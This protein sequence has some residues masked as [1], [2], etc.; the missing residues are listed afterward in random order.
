MSCLAK[1]LVPNCIIDRVIQ[2]QLKEADLKPETK[3]RL[4]EIKCSITV[5]GGLTLPAQFLENSEKGPSHES[6]ISKNIDLG[7]IKMGEGF[8]D[9]EP[10][11][12]KQIHHN[13]SQKFSAVILGEDDNFEKYSCA[14]KFTGIAT[15]NRCL[16]SL[17]DSDVM[18]SDKEAAPLLEDLKIVQDIGLPKSYNTDFNMQTDESFS[19]IFFYGMG[20][21]LLTKQEKVSESDLGPF[22]IDM[23][24]QDLEVRK[25]YRELGARVHFSQDQKVTGI[26]DYKNETLFK[27]GDDG[28]D[29]AK[30]LAKCTA[31]VLMTV[32]EHLVWTHLIVSNDATRESTLN[33]PPNHPIRR[34]LTVF[35]FNANGVNLEAFDQLVPNTSTLF[36]SAGF[37][38]KAM[39]QVF[40]LSYTTSDVYEP[41]SSRTYN[42]AI[43]KLVEDGKMPYITQGSEYYDIVKAFVR[44]WLEQAGDTATDQQSM[45]FYEGMRQSSLGQKY[46]LPAADTED[47]MVNL[48]STII[49]TVTCYH[50]LIGHVVDYVEA[51][52]RA[53]FRLCKKDPSS[54]DLQ[55]LILTGLIGGATSVKMPSL[56]REFP[57]FFG[58]GGAPDWEIDVWK[59]FLEDLEEQSK[60]V[61]EEIAKGEVE[62]KYFD[63]HNF[64]CSVSV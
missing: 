53:G 17:D 5:M 60:K 22:E 12:V 31:F 8:D 50:E 63:P 37:T 64:E 16:F 34:L 45:N 52:S 32:R 59:G 41:F 35:T 46:E 56:M 61:K 54:I 4:E 2:R 1:L 58:K 42:P 38:Y 55:S 23:P 14:E 36:R 7:W 9:W 15:R 25:L 26:Y 21:V 6:L 43:K 30:M 24:L 3:E 27:P 39:K 49:F 40:D 20:C 44:K 28:W 29:N 11:D 48:C 57:N 51:P 47:A 13:I 62:F 19:R 10:S 18:I 33:L